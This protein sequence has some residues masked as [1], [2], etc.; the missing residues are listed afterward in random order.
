MRIDKALEQISEIHEH[1]A[2]SQVFRGYRA[3][4][5]VLAGA[6]ALTAAWVQPLLV[7]GAPPRTFVLYWTVAAIGAFLTAG[8][9]VIIGYVRERDP[10]LRRR[11]AVVVGQLTPS[12]AVGVIL[13]LAFLISDD[14]NLVCFLPGIWALLYALGLAASRPYLPRMVGWVVVFYV[15]C[16]CFVLHRALNGSQSLSPWEVGVPFGVGHIFGGLVLYWNLERKNRDTN[17]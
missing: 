5:W 9:S 15:L 8:G 16:G 17:R 7:P 6:L 10:H 11:T 13:T 1:M 2:K 3:V 12:L 4:P 14:N